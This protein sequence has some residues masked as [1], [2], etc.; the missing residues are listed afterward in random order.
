MRLSA[1]ADWAFHRYC[2]IS[3]RLPPVTGRS[4][5]KPEPETVADLDAIAGSFDAFLFD[6]FGVLNV[7]A[8]SIAGASDRI[9]QLR[10]M[11]KSVFVLTNAATLPLGDNRQKYHDLGFDF[12]EHEIISSRAILAGYLADL[13]TNLVWGI[14]APE[15]S[16]INE[17]PCNSVLLDAENV[18][19]CD[20]IILLSSANWDETKQE[21]LV[22]SLAEN[23]R[24]VLVGNPDLVA[25]RE[26][27]FSK[28]P[29]F[30]AHDLA[31]RLDIEPLFFGKP[32]Q[33][34]FD[35]AFARLPPGIEPDRVLM[36]GDTLH[37]DILG[38]HAAGCK[39][40]LVVDHGLMRDTNIRNAMEQSGVV[41][42]YIM[43]SI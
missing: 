43:P 39:T 26:D 38:G 24:P 35:E 14:A 2:K 17:L 42:D 19:G 41:P 10:N 27:V 40:A 37:T 22:N 34:A 4:P 21:M 13:S 28:E 16:R 7:G 20:G 31:D 36:L 12:S 25:P 5:L 3:N 8:T 15:S 1:S 33:N 11:G 23:P 32:F 6:S 30:F 9:L 29:G 18:S